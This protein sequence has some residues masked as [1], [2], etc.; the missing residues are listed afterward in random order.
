MRQSSSLH[1]YIQL[2]LVAI[3]LMFI[4]FTWFAMRPV[5]LV[6]EMQ[7]NITNQKEDITRSTISTLEENIPAIEYFD[8]MVN[9]PLFFENRQPFVY[10]QAV[11][12]SVPKEQKKNTISSKIEYS[13]HAVVITPKKKIAIIQSSKTKKIQRVAE[14]TKVDD[15]KLEHIEPREIRLA[16]D[17]EIKILVL[18]V[19]NSSPNKKPATTMRTNTKEKQK[20]NIKLNTWGARE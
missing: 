17:D 16:R 2:I 1:R 8:E 6:V 5:D 9:R 10:K 15:W 13:L 12:K 3:C 19:K 7:N 18:E 14:G 20:K 4:Y 11:K